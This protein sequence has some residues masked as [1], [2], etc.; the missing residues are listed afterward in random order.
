M[1]KLAITGGLGWLGRELCKRALKVGTA[2]SPVAKASET[3]SEVVL[4]DAVPPVNAPED[5]RVKVSTGS[6]S[7]SG[8]DWARRLVDTDNVAVVHLASMMSGNSEADF[9]AAWEVNCV[10]MRSLLE[11]LRST[12]TCPRIVFTS[13]TAALM[14][15]REAASDLTK[16]V[17]ENTYGWTKGTC[18]LM[19][20]EYSR[21]GFVDGRGL[22]LPVVVVRPGPP[23]AAATGAYSSVVRETLQG[24]DF[25]C[26]LPM[27][28]RAPM[29][30]YQVAVDNMW[31]LLSN[32]E[33]SVRAAPASA[34][35]REWEAH[36]G[37]SRPSP[38]RPSVRTGSLRT[39]PSPRPVGSCTRA[40]ALSRRRRASR[41]GRAR[42]K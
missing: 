4:F 2:Y 22:R 25:A 3:I 33:S 28:C 27:A 38:R 42:S 6:L 11:A 7:D 36:S 21:R 23:N 24:N 34:P 18:E 30:S 14:P 1:V 35:P 32:V 10:G 8:G 5:P 39:Q 29:T 40:H 13:S 9:D 26:P 17:P 37:G 19:L 20:N 12:G 41:A 16:I 15:T 31:H